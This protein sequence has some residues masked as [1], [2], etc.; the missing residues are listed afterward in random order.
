MGWDRLGGHSDRCLPNPFFFFNA[1]KPFFS[2]PKSLTEHLH[3]EHIKQE[4]PLVRENMW[5]LQL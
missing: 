4:L 3:N 2:N 5:G 1:V